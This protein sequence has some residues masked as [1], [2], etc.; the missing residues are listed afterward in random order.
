MLGTSSILSGC[1]RGGLS[2][3]PSVPGGLPWTSDV[4][5]MGVVGLFW[6]MGLLASGDLSRG[7][8][9]G[10]LPEVFGGLGGGGGTAGS[11]PNTT[12]NVCLQKITDVLNTPI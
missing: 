1:L 6:S 4:R 2:L 12:V 11:H 3:L 10:P 7:R 8:G 9:D 5:T